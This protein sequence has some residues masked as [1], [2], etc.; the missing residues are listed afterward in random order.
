MLFIFYFCYV[1]QF[2]MSDQYAFSGIKY[3]TISDDTF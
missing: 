3:Q 2:F 1:M